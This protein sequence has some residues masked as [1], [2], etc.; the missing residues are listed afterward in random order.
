MARACIRN[1]K[2]NYLSRLNFINAT[3]NLVRLIDIQFLI[4]NFQSTKSK[5]FHNFVCPKAFLMEFISLF[6]FFLE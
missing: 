6:P 3:Y 1:Q 4:H 5:L 2:P